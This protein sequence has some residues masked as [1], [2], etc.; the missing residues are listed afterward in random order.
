MRNARSLILQA[1]MGGAH[2]QLQQKH[3]RSLSIKS[4]KLAINNIPKV[5][6]DIAYPQEEIRDSFQTV[7]ILLTSF[8]S[9][10][11][12]DCCFS[13]SLVSDI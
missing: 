9:R 5:K 7:E 12:H 6:I 13:A 2:L 1:D 3:L 8:L 11:H 4:T 10:L